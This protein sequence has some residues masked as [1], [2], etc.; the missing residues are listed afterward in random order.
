MQHNR[1]L[2]GNDYLNQTNEIV[3]IISNFTGILRNMEAHTY[4]LVNNNRFNF[5]STHPPILTRPRAIFNAPAQTTNDT[6]SGLFS[7]LTP[8]R[9]H[10]SFEQIRTA[11]RML[12]FEDIENPMNTRCPIRHEDFQS[13][14]IVMQ[15]IHCRHNFNS[16]ALNRWFENAVRCPVCRY[17]IRDYVAGSEDFLEPSPEPQ[18]PPEEEPLLEPEPSLPESTEIEND[19]SNNTITINAVF[20]RNV[21]NIRNTIITQISNTIE[22]VISTG[23]SNNNGIISI[24]YQVENV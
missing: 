6:L 11:T 19:L 16:S 20:D 22:H 3:N 24:E 14:D 13:G 1:N 18:L 7:N 9:I 4:T 12:N 17:D 10:P 5:T 23:D 15:I 21:D 8:V 2:T